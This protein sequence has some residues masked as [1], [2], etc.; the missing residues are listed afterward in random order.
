MTRLTLMMLGILGAA[1]DITN[2]RMA[3]AL[4]VSDDYAAELHRRL[5]ST[6]HPSILHLRREGL[7]ITYSSPIAGDLLCAECEHRLTTVPCVF[8]ECKSGGRKDR[9]VEVRE[10]GRPTDHLPGSR[11]KVMVMANRVKRGYSAFCEGDAVDLSA[12]REQ[13]PRD[14]EVYYYENESHP[15]YSPVRS[16]GRVSRKVT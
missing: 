16:G 12:G 9:E 6:N 7:P 15:L 1:K 2:H 10:S 3:E 14:M 8:C 13:E 5:L 4:E 11:E